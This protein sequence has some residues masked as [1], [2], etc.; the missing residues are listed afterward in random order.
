MANALKSRSDFPPGDSAV[1]VMSNL[2]DEKLVYIV[3]AEG[4]ADA[5]KIIKL[6]NS[7]VGG[8]GVLR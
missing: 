2:N 5:S 8:G 1:I 7:E 3:A 4:S 6:I